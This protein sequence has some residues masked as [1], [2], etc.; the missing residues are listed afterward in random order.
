MAYED[1]SDSEL[2]DIKS[3]KF[4]PSANS[5]ANSRLSRD[6]TASAKE[7][8]RARK[9][10]VNFKS[11]TREESADPQ[12]NKFKDSKTVRKSQSNY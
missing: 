7:Y 9:Q 3:R 1:S 8:K 2:E 11:L 6:I 4:N 10:D 12:F 5:F